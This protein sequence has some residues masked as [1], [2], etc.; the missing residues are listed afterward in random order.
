M[1][2]LYNTIKINN[3]GNCE[4]AD[5][6]SDL[7]Y[8]GLYQN[9][10]NK[11]IDFPKKEHLYTSFDNSKSL[12]GK[13]FTYS[14]LINT[15]SI[16]R[17]DLIDK[18]NNNFFDYI[19]Y[20]IHHS[21][22]HYQ[23]NI[24]EYISNIN[25]PKDKVIIIDG[26]DDYNINYKLLDFCKVLFKREL[27]INH[28]N[29]LPISFAIPNCKLYY[30][31]VNKNKDYAYIHPGSGDSDWPK[32]SRKTH[33]YDNEIDYYN[34]YRQAKFALT[35]KKGGWDCMRHYEILANK[36]IPIF[37]DIEYCPENTLTNF[38]KKI[39]SDI[40]KLPGINIATRNENKFTFHGYDII[41]GE[42]TIDYSQF[43]NSIYEEYSQLLFDYTEKKLTTKNLGNYI[44]K[45][46]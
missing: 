44:L 3:L 38:P 23:N 1:N 37:T 17:N 2:I 7:T 41:Q 11:I 22:Y 40:K 6:T 33:I 4:I 28:K 31:L 12:W 5:Y 13:G 30:D 36:C 27:R 24:I 29:I 34:D 20:S 8:Y 18:I 25:Y 16:N 9:L 39:L 32:D 45:Y 19:I 46:L 42:S 21:I 14:K 35:C 26:Q 10:Y 15:D 43:N